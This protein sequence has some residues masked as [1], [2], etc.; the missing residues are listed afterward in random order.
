MECKYLAIAA[1][2]L[3]VASCSD[4]PQGWGVAGE[5]KGTE[6]YTLSLEGFNNGFWYNIDSLRTE[7]GSFRYESRTPASFPE[8]MRLGLDGNYIYFPVDSTEKILIHAD[9]ANYAFEYRLEGTRQAATIKSIDSIINASVADRGVEITAADVT[10]K[11]NLFMK[12]FDDPSVMPL[13]YLINK[14]VGDHSIFNPADPSDLRYYGAV[15]QRF[16]T[17]LPDDPRGQLLAAIYKKNRPSKSDSFEIEVPEASI[18]DIVR[19]DINGKKQ[20][21]AEMA[22]KGAVIVLSFTAYSLES[23]PAYNIVLNSIYEKYNQ[24]GLQIYQIAFDE[25]ESTWRQTA[26]N[27]PWTAVWNSTTDGVSPLASY[28]VGALPTTFIIDSTGTIAAR[29]DDPNEIEKTVGRFI[30]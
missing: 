28:N 12:A 25:E 2:T 30:K 24:K 19:T 21:L 1:T 23:S 22:S 18:I 20:S 13:Y 11:R 4:K 16:A 14:S 7:N 15:A 27:L 29:I 17:E 10:L 6:E 3:L 8:I 26:R 5:I 9:A